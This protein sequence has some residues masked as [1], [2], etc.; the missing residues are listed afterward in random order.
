MVVGEQTLQVFTYDTDSQ[1][2]TY[3]NSY[4]DIVKN[5]TAPA[6]HTKHIPN[7]DLLIIGGFYGDVFSFFLYY[8]YNIL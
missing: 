7:T 6:W 3:R 8:F 1:M 4:Y 5:L 2:F